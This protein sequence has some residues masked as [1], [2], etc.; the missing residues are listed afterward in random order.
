MKVTPAK[1]WVLKMKNVA[2]V[3]NIIFFIKVLLFYINNNAM[4][5]QF[6]I[7]INGKKMFDKSDLQ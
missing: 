4:V 1:H 3:K 7:F 5:T 6:N 2:K